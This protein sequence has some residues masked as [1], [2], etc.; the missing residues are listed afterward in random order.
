M[1]GIEFLKGN[2][3]ELPLPVNL[4]IN[5][6]FL[7]VKNEISIYF[8]KQ[9]LAKFKLTINW[10]DHPNPFCLMRRVFRVKFP[11]LVFDSGKLIKF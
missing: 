5:C 2:F 10:S 1:P 7:R 8:A 9:F 3:S 11:V 4:P 6:P